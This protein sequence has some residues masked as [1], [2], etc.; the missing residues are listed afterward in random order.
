MNRWRNPWR[1]LWK[2]DKFLIITKPREKFLRNPEKKYQKNYM[3]NQW[4]KLKKYMEVSLKISR[5]N[6]L[7]IFGR[8]TRKKNIFFEETQ[9]K[10]LKKKIIGKTM[11]KSWKESRH[12][13]LKE[14]SKESLFV[15]WKKFQKETRRNP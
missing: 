11:M 4:R 10:A 5:W 3:W 13:S 8:N 2:Q 15:S 14:S 7:L 12:E 9:E 1:N 6:S